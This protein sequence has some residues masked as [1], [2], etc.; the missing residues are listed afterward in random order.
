M[1]ARAVAVLTVCLVALATAAASALAESLPADAVPPEIAEP[2]LSYAN[3]LAAGDPAEAWNLLSAESRSRMTAAAWEESFG[4]PEE[5]RKPPAKMVINALAQAETW[6]TDGDV[7]VRDGEALVAVKGPIRITQQ[8]VMVR[9]DNEWRVDLAA[10]D[11]IN[12]RGAAQIFIDMLRAE[13][14]AAGNLRGGKSQPMRGNMSLL[15]LFFAEYAK[16]YQIAG[17]EVNADRARI[18]MVANIPVSAVVR[19]KRIGP[20]WMVDMAQPLLYTEP[21]APDPLAEA[22]GA[23]HAAA[24]QEQLANLFLAFNMYL[25]ASDNMF[26]DPDRW[27]DQ[28]RPYL[29]LTAELHCPADPDDGISYAMNRNLGGKQRSNITNHGITPLLFESALHTPNAADTG[30]SWVTPSRHPGGNHV[31]FVDSSVRARERKPFFK[32][33]KGKPSPSRATGGPGQSITIPSP[34]PVPRR[35]PR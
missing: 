26:P 22:V 12:T 16:E 19:A 17:A 1:I 24:C 11:E 20:G 32:V 25:A 30:Q 13:P 8:L 9:D 33:T 31:L 6:A 18:T 7:L 29:P 14:G 23:E 4:A 10:S 21:T 27:L 5:R 28:I 35:G 2:A 15:Q 34:R 3:A